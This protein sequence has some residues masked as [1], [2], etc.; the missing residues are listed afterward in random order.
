MRAPS[1]LLHIQRH[2]R[3][4]I[5]WSLALGVLAIILAGIL[6]YFGSAELGRLR[7]HMEVRMTEML[8]Q[9]VRIGAMESHWRVGPWMRLKDVRVGDPRQP[10]ILLP[11][12]DV[13]L[14]PLPLLW[15]RFAVRHLRLERPYLAVERLADGRLKVGGKVLGGAGDALSVTLD[16]ADMDIRNGILDWQDARHPGLGRLRLQQLNVQVQSRFRQHVQGSVTL[17]RQLGSEIRIRAAARHLFSDPLDSRGEA[18]VTIR[19]LHTDLLAGYFAEAL[20]FTIGGT[21]S[22]TLSGAW[23]EAHLTRLH[24]PLRVDRPALAWPTYYHQPLHANSL[25]LQLDWRSQSNQGRLQLDDVRLARPG[26]RW[27]PFNVVLHSSLGDAP[28]RIALKVDRMEIGPTLHLLPPKLLPP[29]WQRYLAEAR[30]QGL[31]ED[32][33]LIWQEGS[34]K[35]AEHFAVS[36]RFTRLHT[37]PVDKSPGF[38]NLSGE[39]RLVNQD[40]ALRLDSQDVLLDW[41]YAFRQTLPIQRLRSEAS[42]QWTG[43]RLTVRLPHFQLQ[44]DLNAEGH[45]HIV[46][47]PGQRPYLALDARA[48]SVSAAHAPRYYPYRI[49]HPA[50]LHWLDNALLQGRIDQARVQL[51]GPLSKFPFAN[52]KDG[53]FRVTSHVSDVTLRYDPKWPVATRLSGRMDFVRQGFALQAERGAI[54]DA[55]IRRLNARIPDLLSHNPQLHI[56]GLI[57]T[58]FNTGLRFLRASPILRDTAL[59]RAKISA[60]GMSPLALKLRI[61]LGHQGGTAVDGRLDLRQVDLLWDNWRVEQISGPLYFT[62]HEIQTPGLE[63]QWLG[64]PTRVQLAVDTLEHHP[65]VRILAHGQAAP[66]ALKAQLGQAWLDHI[67]GGIPYLLGVR[68]QD[69]RGSYA[70]QSPLQGVAIRLPEPLAKAPETTLPLQAQG[71]FILNRELGIRA[72]LGQRHAAQL[73]LANGTGGWMPTRGAWQLG[74]D[75][76]PALPADGFRLQGRGDVLPLSA[77]LALLGGGEGGTGDWPRIDVDMSWRTVQALDRDWRE[78]AVQGSVTPDRQLTLRL[79]G[80]AVQGEIRYAHP[81]GQSERLAA[82]FARLHVPAPQPRPAAPVAAALT[83]PAKPEDGPLTPAPAATPLR[84]EANIRGL[85]WDDYQIDQLAFTA[86]RRP[87]LW[88]LPQI[89]IREEDARFD[90]GGTWSGPGRGQTQIQGRFEAQNV[91]N[92]L[93][94][95]AFNSGLSQGQAQLDGQLSWPGWPLDFD[96]ARLDGRIALQLEEGRFT[97][98]SPVV[99]ILSLMNVTSMFRRVFTL[100]FRDLTG[101]GLFFQ[102]LG[103]QLVLDDGV[104]RTDDLELKSSAVRVLAEGDI[105]LRSRLLDL[106]MHVHPLQTVDLLLGRFP[107]LGPALFGKDGSVV[108][109][110]YQASGPWQ[111]PTIAPIS[112]SRRTSQP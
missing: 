72:T 70:L 37:H 58:S 51:R 5:R 50:L 68:L 80:P 64:G 24:G 13:E 6:I 73:L 36:N 52:P 91:A 107:I 106:Q 47:T 4:L 85:R 34:A 44:G 28:T 48:H 30:P 112:R 59:G 19:N 78:L 31:V 46:Q 81:R 14:H 92:T 100:D 42:W 27:R 26:E 83:A 101:K 63:G 76:V 66:A 35:Q 38:R 97:E 103:G 86:E 88:Q 69:E 39:I 90:G 87:G 25:A 111:N 84:L 93:R 29:A 11:Q 75:S 15:G 20:P 49:M 43:E 21:V 71:D 110:H 98:V 61:G 32:F 23:R 2:L 22:G 108:D 67:E 79:D 77:W 41:P 54:F 16:H 60:T 53:E 33:Q 104:A 82:D 65:Q 89:R 45:A 3:A 17:P 95:L 12:M 94:K 96:P 10:Q 8:G 9:P 102:H 105:D 1:L 99:K 40:G 7:P 55:P 74:S 18:T 62:R 56:D 109:L 57:D